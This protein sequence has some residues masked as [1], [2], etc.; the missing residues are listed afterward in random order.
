METAVTRS[1]LAPRAGSSRTIGNGLRGVIAAVPTPVDASGGPDHARFLQ[2]ASHLLDN[3]C[4]ALN[5]L[6]TTGE[7]TSFSIEQRL[8]LMEAAV[9]ALPRHR[10]MVGTGAAALADARQLTQAAG[11]MQFAAALVLPPFYYKGVSDDGILAYFDQ[12]VNS[13][14]G[15]IPLYLY[16]F[17]ALSGVPFGVE[18]IARL[19]SELGDR[20]AGLK[21]SSGNIAYAREVAGLSEELLVFPSDEATLLEARSGTFAGCIS[22]TANLNAELCAS[23]YHEGDALALQKAVAIRRLFEGRPLVPCVKAMLARNH[24]D[25][26]LARVVPPLVDCPIGDAD[27][28]YK[29][30]RRLP[31]PGL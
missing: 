12:L 22:A 1:T 13:T 14:R 3:G 9:T 20:I 6:G 26:Q 8:G 7:A 10:L 24:G 28:L 11:E 5:V 31:Q 15:N 27:E 25:D 30:Y 21:D 4:D 23:A 19:R 2:L 16:N 29:R 18:L 17:P